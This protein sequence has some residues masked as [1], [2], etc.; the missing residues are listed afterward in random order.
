MNYLK[1][2]KLCSNC[3]NKAKIQSTIS[4]MKTK[5]KYKSMH[6]CQNYANIA[7]ICTKWEN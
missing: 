5:Q 2:A 7:K 6:K 4:T 1:I 3:E